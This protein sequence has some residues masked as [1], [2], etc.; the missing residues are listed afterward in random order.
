[1]KH[2]KHLAVAALLAVASV[3]AHAVTMSDITG[4]WRSAVGAPAVI[5]G[6]DTTSTTAS[7]G[8]AATSGGTSSYSFTA[9][10]TPFNIPLGAAFDLGTF[11]HRNF[12]IFPPSI[13]S[14]S[15]DVDYT[16]DGFGQRT[17]SF[18]FLHEETTNAV[19][20][21][22]PGGAPCADRVRLVNTTA[23]SQ[24]F[25]IGG[26]DYGL[27]IL[28]F[29]V[30]DTLFSQFITFENLSNGAVLQARLVDRTQFSNLVPEPAPLA[31][32]GLGLAAL[33]VAGRKRS[34]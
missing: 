13:S 11:V 20:C 31:L 7:W 21:A 17:G 22:Y 29:K 5:T 14:I 16:V 26:I 28:G 12:P 32:L 10:P 15:L 6:C 3:G 34:K 19:P 1:M 30:G 8:T 2:L 24:F 18:D 4:C 23:P 25:N 9:T 33:G 27:D